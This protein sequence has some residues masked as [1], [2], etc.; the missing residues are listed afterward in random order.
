[1]NYSGINVTDSG[2]FQMY[3]PSLYIGSNDKGVKFR[4]PFAGREYFITPEEDMNDIKSYCFGYYY[5]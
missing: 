4:D 5:Y 3:S 1:M 2:G